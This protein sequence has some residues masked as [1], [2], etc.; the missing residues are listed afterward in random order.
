VFAQVLLDVQ[1]LAEEGRVSP[2]ELELRLTPEDL[3]IL[4]EKPNVAV[5]YPIET[6]DR[7]TRVLLEV[8]GGGRIDYVRQRGV[9]ASA[10]LFESGLY[11]QLRKA[12]A[13]T[14]GEREGQFTERDGRLMV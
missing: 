1:R 3:A 14:G 6:Y 7:M 12:Q 2:E 9:A 10:R 5:W 13:G 8:E 4:A 11:S